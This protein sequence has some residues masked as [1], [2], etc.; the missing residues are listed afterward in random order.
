MKQ[1]NAEYDILRSC[2][3]C[4]NLL[5]FFLNFPYYLSRFKARKFLRNKSRNTDTSGGPPLIC[6][7]HSTGA[8]SK[9]NTGY[10]MDNIFE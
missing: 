6:V 10:N 3:N 9:G 8:Y 5:L 7:Q 2:V 1:E 4:I